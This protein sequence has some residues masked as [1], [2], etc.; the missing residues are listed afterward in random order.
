MI[1][2]NNGGHQE[3]SQEA[4][5]SGKNAEDCFNTV[6]KN[7]KDAGQTGYNQL[8]NCENTA[9]QNLNTVLQAFDNEQAVCII[10]LY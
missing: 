9:N 3:K 10:F 7:M 2:I 8:N 6:T 5:E 4:K 1:N